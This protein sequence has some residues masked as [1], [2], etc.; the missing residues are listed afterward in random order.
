MISQS[1]ASS[2]TEMMGVQSED[3]MSLHSGFQG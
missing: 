2:A 1:M 3:N